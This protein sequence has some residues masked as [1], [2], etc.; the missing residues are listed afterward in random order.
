MISTLASKH[1]NIL[2]DKISKYYLDFPLNLY[3]EQ[4][5]QWRA[6]S[7]CRMKKQ[8][9][10]MFQIFKLL[11]RIWWEG[12]DWIKTW[13]WKMENKDWGCSLPG[14]SLSDYCQTIVG[15]WL[16]LLTFLWNSVRW[17]WTCLKAKNLHSTVTP[18]IVNVFIIKCS[19]DNLMCS[20]TNYLE[21]DYVGQ[22]YLK[23]LEISLIS[24]SETERA[25]ISKIQWNVRGWML[26]ML[27]LSQ[28]QQWLKL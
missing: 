13:L 15:L 19:V 2:S 14:G 5:G 26:D 16:P 12:R 6:D 25:D 10:Q 22:L 4:S 28:E 9:D 11:K 17:C 27:D 24:I 8:K 23:Y 21:Q 18:V 1:R 20:Q 7:R 3:F